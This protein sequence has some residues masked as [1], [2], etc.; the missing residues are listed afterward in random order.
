MLVL[1]RH[2]RAQSWLE[3]AYALTLLTFPGLRVV[4][5][6]PK[7]GKAGRPVKWT[8]DAAVLVLGAREAGI[9]I[10]RKRGETQPT[11]KRAI[12]EALVAK[13]PKLRRQDAY[14]FGKRFARRLSDL[15]K[16]LRK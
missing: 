13:I 8:R 4:P 14:A 7:K 9:E 16:L 15:E 2:L 6:A 12:A 1:Q 10:L 3:V 5:L 11:N